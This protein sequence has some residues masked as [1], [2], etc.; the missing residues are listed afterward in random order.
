LGGR[1]T[2][3]L[4]FGPDIGQEILYYWYNNPEAAERLEI[5]PRI[6]ELV[7]RLQR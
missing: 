1:T 6:Q 3:A 2:F 5:P 4:P 7:N